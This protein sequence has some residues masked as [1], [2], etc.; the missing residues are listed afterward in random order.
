MFEHRSDVAVERVVMSPPISSTTSAYA[1]D[2]QLNFTGDMGDEVA[3]LA[4]NGAL[5]TA[6]IEK[7]IQESEQDVADHEYDQEI[8]AMRKKADDERGAGLVDGCV[9]MASGALQAVNTAVD[10]HATGKAASGPAP[11]SKGVDDWFKVA[12]TGLDGAGKIGVALFKSAEDGEDATAK[13]DAEAGA[14]ADQASKDAHDE[15]AAQ[16]AVADKALDF[17]RQYVQTQAST[18]LAIAQ[19]V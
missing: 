19:R 17:E 12:T 9:G 11:S 15:A 7:Q 8:A 18:Y 2:P 1:F 6:T 14:R 10:L 16:Q 13:A 5:D 4:V 3:A